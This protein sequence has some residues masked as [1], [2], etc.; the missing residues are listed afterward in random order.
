MSPL[1][2][3]DLVGRAGTSYR[4][5]IGSADLPAEQHIRRCH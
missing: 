4:R 3:P 2:W 1:R 5:P